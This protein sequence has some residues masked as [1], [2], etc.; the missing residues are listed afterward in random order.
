MTALEYL[1]E[2]SECAARYEHVL[3]LNQREA[4]DIHELKPNIENAV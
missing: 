1:Y 2:T 4:G 3:N